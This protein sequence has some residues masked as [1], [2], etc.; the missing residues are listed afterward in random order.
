MPPDARIA[1]LRMSFENAPRHAARS[2]SGYGDSHDGLSVIAL[3]VPT[4]CSANANPRNDKQ[5]RRAFPTGKLDHITLL[6]FRA[7]EPQ[8]HGYRL[9]SWGSCDPPFFP[10][11]SEIIPTGIS[12]LPPHGL[13]FSWDAQ[14]KNN[15]YRLAKRT[16]SL[17][18]RPRAPAVTA[19]EP[20]TK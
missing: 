7:G 3:H 13:L 8:R 10:I 12:M 4:R 2:P 11:F 1:A 16:T 18:W 15:M 5:V 20:L 17:Q 9:L 14:W 6:N 19:Q